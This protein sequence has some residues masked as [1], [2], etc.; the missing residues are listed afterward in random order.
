MP[1]EDIL[2]IERFST[3][4]QWADGNVLLAER[5]Y[6]FNVQLSS[7]FYSSL[8][9][10]EIALRN[11]ADEA[12][13]VSYGVNWLESVGVLVDPYQQRC[14]QDACSAL[15]R[16]K[17][18]ATHSQIIAELN[19]GFWSSL[20]GRSSNHLWGQ[21]MRPIFNKT[22]LQRSAIAE[23]LRNLRRLR[24]RVAHYEPILAQPLISLRE[25]LLEL[26]LWLSGDA[27][28]WI[29]R[30]SQIV[31]PASPIIIVDSR[32]GAGVFNKSLLRYLPN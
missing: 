8:H 23:K 14:V 7:D 28:S 30:H 24:N 19:F 6:S 4:K 27:H 17:K 10:L 20:F 9:M 18:M 32:T 15:Q 13:I 2:S 26:T 12:L 31:Y 22:G 21:T 3:Y 16:E 29:L 11:K 1:L 5:L 25:D